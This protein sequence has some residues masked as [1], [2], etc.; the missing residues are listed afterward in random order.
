M[1]NTLY[2]RRYRRL[3]L[4]LTLI[5]GLIP[6]SILWSMFYKGE[7]S[8]YIASLIMIFYTIGV[9]MSVFEK[10]KPQ[11]REIVVVAVL[12]A[13]AVT[14]RMAFFMIPQ[15]KPVVAIVILSAVSLG[16]EMGFVVGA[17][18]G[19]VSN[20]FFGQG[21]WTPWQMIAFGLIGFFAGFLAE[22][23]IFKKGKIR[24]CTFGG[25]ATFFIYGGI[26]N[27]C[28]V[29]MFTSHPTKSAFIA[30]YISGFWFDM[31]HSFATVVFLK[32]LGAPMLQKLERVKKKYSLMHEEDELLWEEKG[33]ENEK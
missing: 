24:L 20:F 22:K 23:E 14:G 28:S 27:P 32:L 30:A 10:R 33:E 16:A 12:T 25:I 1:P 8:Y 9:F 2:K 6:F 3:G 7:R 18:S 5:L 15:F 11:T 17:M 4:I 31:I 29:I 19:F 13:L 21:P 26:M